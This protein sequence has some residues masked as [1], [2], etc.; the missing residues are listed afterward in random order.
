MEVITHSANFTQEEFNDWMLRHVPEHLK[1]R[2]EAV[3]NRSDEARQAEEDRTKLKQSEH[4]LEQYRQRAHDNCGLRGDQWEDTWETFRRAGTAEE[5]DSQ[6]TALREA[7]SRS[8]QFPDIQRGLMFVGR[9]GVG[10]DFFLHCIVRD[11]LEKTAVYDVRYFYSLNLEKLFKQ[12]WYGDGDNDVTDLEMCMRN[13]NI[14]LLGDLHK[15]LHVKSEGIVNAMTRVL[16]QICD[17]GH[18]KLFCSSMIPLR[19]G[20]VGQDGKRY[21]YESLFGESIASWLEGSVDEITV[22]GPN[23]R[24]RAAA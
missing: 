18:P 3:L 12:E 17:E 21:D 11:V 7:H 19:H 13:C 16:K 9:P 24:N 1:P 5:K 14:L 4:M 20:P 2:I 15:I 6:T 22:F 23:R 8:E 10:K